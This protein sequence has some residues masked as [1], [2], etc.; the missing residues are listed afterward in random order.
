MHDGSVASLP[1][2]LE[3]TPP[4]RP[5]VSLLLRRASCLGAGSRRVN[6][7]QRVDRW[8]SL[9]A[10]IALAA[11]GYEP[12][13]HLANRGRR[14]ADIEKDLASAAS[15]GVRRV[16]CIRGEYKAEDGE[17]TPRIRE[18][19]RLVYRRLPDAQVS[20]TLNPFAAQSA[21]SR[22]RVFANL[23]AKLDAGA[24]GVQTQVS[25]DLQSLQPFA[26]KLK[27]ERPEVRITPMLMP[28][29]SARAAVRI[30]RRLGVPL[31][32]ALLHRLERLGPDA[33]WDHFEAFA[34]AVAASPLYDGLAVMTPIDPS[35]AFSSRLRAAL[36][37]FRV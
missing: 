30:S 6:V 21:S 29:E 13:W 18:L 11:R 33:G 2:T 14:F 16:L 26:E 23:E 17:D 7:I 9:P 25:F 24:D 19:V 15:T 32:A 36:G 28:V 34:R 1:I 27:S 20:V 35:P 12:V 3:I 8:G 10:S 31:P 4:V 37:R 5:Q 22:A